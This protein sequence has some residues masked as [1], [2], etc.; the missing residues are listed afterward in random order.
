MKDEN[1]SILTKIDYGI[2][3]V[4]QELIVDCKGQGGFFSEN[5]GFFDGMLFGVIISSG[6]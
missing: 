2:A 5:D 4:R 3:P 1:I 6:F